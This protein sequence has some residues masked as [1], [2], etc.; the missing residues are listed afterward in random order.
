MAT[1]YK[2]LKEDGDYLL[3]EDGDNILVEPSYST[4]AG[5]TPVISV[6]TRSP[7]VDATHTSH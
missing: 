6:E 5:M 3:K 2:L 7:K 4:R 1:Y